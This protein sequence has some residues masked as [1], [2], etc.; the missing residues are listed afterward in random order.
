MSTTLVFNSESIPETDPLLFLIKLQLLATDTWKDKSRIARERIAQ[1]A[2]A[3]VDQNGLHTIN[4]GSELQRR[5]LS[6]F[7]APA[8]MPLFGFFDSRRRTAPGRLAFPDDRVERIW[9][10][11]HVFLMLVGFSADNTREFVRWIL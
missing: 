6:G 11:L 9:Q 10:E 4:L 1:V 3:V 7:L 5:A 2:A 8:Y